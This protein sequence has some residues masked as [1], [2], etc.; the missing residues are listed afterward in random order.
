VD[1]IERAGSVTAG[2]ELLQEDVHVISVR[3][4]VHRLSTTW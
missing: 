2:S 3:V 1:S 4:G